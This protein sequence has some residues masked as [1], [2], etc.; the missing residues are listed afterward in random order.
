MRN[1]FAEGAS[2]AEKVAARIGRSLWQVKSLFL[3]AKDIIIHVGMALQEPFSKRN[4]LGGAKK[5]TVREDAPESLRYFVLDTAR[6]LEYA[7]SSFASFT[8]ESAI[9]KVRLASGQCRSSS[10]GRRR[11]CN[12]ASTGA[13][14]N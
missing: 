9:Q 5:I 11:G 10:G 1:G 4:C 8:R 2:Q 6:Q 7:P 13:I 12:T 3:P 14:R